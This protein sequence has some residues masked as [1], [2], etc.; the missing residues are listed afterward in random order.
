MNLQKETGP[1]NLEQINKIIP[2]PLRLVR[3]AQETPVFKLPFLELYLFI[4]FWLYPWSSF[5]LSA[6]LVVE[7]K[8]PE[9][10]G[11][12]DELRSGRRLSCLFFHKGR[13]CSHF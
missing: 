5:S 8:T 3:S 11:G 6:W 9:Y 12:K 7:K 13:V 1:L 4:K 10:V 2:V